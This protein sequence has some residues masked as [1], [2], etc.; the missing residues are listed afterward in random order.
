[1]HA[2]HLDTNINITNSAAGQVLVGFI[3]ESVL[4]INA[5][6]S[7]TA[8]LAEAEMRGAATSRQH[9]WVGNSTRSRTEPSGSLHSHTYPAATVSTPSVGFLTFIGLVDDYDVIVEDDQSVVISDL[10]AEQLKQGHLLLSGTGKG[11]AAGRVTIQ[12]VK[13]SA[14]ADWAKI[15]NYYGSLFYMSSCFLSMACA[16]C[17]WTI[18]QQ[19][20]LFHL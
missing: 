11:T 1:M 16:T 18:T 4:T 9:Q 6:A 20:T 15:D 8:E 10:Y 19:G 5:P 7:T 12:G 2:I 17:P 13:S 14:T 3:A